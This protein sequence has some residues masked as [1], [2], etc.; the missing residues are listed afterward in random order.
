MTTEE[1]SQGQAAWAGAP[2]NGR[3]NSATKLEPIEI[4]VVVESGSSPTLINA[5]QPAWQSAANKTARK[6]RF[7]NPQAFA[8]A[9]AQSLGP[10][11][12]Y[13]TGRA[14]SAPSVLAACQPQCGSSRKQRAIDTI[15]ASPFATIRSACSGLTIKPTVRVGMPDSFL[16]RAAIGTL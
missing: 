15:S 2:T 9:G 1:I 8:A 13:C 3:K 12:A 6:T 5:F 4:K 11:R 7:S 16:T 14:T 10:A